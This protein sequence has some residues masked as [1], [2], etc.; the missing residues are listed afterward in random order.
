[1]HQISRSVRCCIAWVAALAIVTVAAVGRWSADADDA[2]RSSAAK[3]D[4]SRAA[5]HAAVE[6]NLGYC[7]DWLAA[8]DWKSL[9][10]SADGVGILVAVLAR[11]GDGDKWRSGVEDLSASVETLCSAADAKEPQK[12]K[13]LIERLSASNKELAGLA[14]KTRPATARSA[15]KPIESLRPLMT[16]LDGTHADAK[17][18]LALGEVAEAKSMAVV[19]SELGRVVSNQRGD[20]AWRAAAE[21]MI[22]AAPRRPTKSRP[23]PKRSAS[24][25]RGVYEKC[26]ACHNRQR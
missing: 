6:K 21:A 17:A 9:R 24:S 1:M 8:K 7:R 26:E 2:A 3:A 18:A 12:S 16:L 22:R 5:L 11:Q 4:R 10:Q 14:V 15:A 20:A 19:L 25:W 13:E 23:T